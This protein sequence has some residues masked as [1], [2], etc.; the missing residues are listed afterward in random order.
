ME[1]KQPP[2]GKFQS[3]YEITKR[4]SYGKS[5]RSWSEEYK[6]YTYAKDLFIRFKNGKE[7][8]DH[9]DRIR[10]LHGRDREK[11]IRDELQRIYLGEHDKKN[12]E[13]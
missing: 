9:L 8:R 10:E 3:I 12:K 1:K 11:L 4:T 6:T 5:M 2:I 7:R 13:S